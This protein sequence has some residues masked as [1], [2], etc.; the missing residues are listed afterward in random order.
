VSQN[1]TFGVLRLTLNPVSYDWQFVPEAGG[2]FTDSGSHA[3]HGLV[4]PPPPPVARDATAPVLS[5]VRLRPRPI[6]RTS[7]FSYVLSEAA[8]VK[9]TIRRKGK[10]RYR[11]V[12][13]F[14]ESAAAGANQRRFRAR[15]RNRRLRPGTFKAVLRATDAAGN[16]SRS[17]SIDF[18]VVQRTR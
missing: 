13:A 4:A 8:T 2:S 5:R 16:R 6:R 12:G 14:V 9:F 10:Q 18:R 3:C 1:T 17:R 7:S 15:I 11:S